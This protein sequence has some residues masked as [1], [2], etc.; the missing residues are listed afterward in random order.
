MLLILVEAV[1]YVVVQ[2]PANITVAVP[3]LLVGVGLLELILVG[4][5]HRTTR[6]GS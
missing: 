2:F 1:E 3:L 5:V 4:V 6:V